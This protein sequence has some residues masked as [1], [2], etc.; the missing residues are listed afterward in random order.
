MNSNIVTNAP[1]LLLILT[2]ICLSLAGCFVL[3]EEEEV[4]GPPLVEPPEITYD[5]MK[6]E[7]KTIENAISAYGHMAPRVKKDLFFRYEGGQLTGLF[8][9]F[10]QSVEKGQ[11]LAELNLGNLENNAEQQKVV[12]EKARIEYEMLKSLSETGL[13]VNNYELRL[14]QMDIR[15]AELQLEDL[16]T[17]LDSARLISPITGQV[18]FIDA[19]EGDYIEPFQ[20]IIRV[21]DPSELILECYAGEASDFFRFDMILDVTINNEIYQGRIIQSPHDSPTQFATVRP[22]YARE[23]EEDESIIID[24]MGLPADVQMNEIGTFHYVLQKQENAIVLPKRVVQQYA[25]RSYVN[26]LV[27]GLKEERDVELGI[28][29]TTEVE[30]A[31]GLEE[32]D[33]VIMR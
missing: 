5:V 7:R 12:L 1:G 2:I 17:S 15:L 29:K 14:A 18:V 22:G 13:A 31:N 16:Q 26:V 3:P 33:L 23:E 6:A 21:V 25:G 8:V 4:L 20:P 10:G 28:Q 19:K 27:N 30:I 32:G 24:V 9:E 11:V